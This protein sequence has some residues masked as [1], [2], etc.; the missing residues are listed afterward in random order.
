MKIKMKSEGRYYLNGMTPTIFEKG[1]EYD[2]PD[3]VGKYFVSKG[4][5]EKEEEGDLPKRTYNKRK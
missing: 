3:K 5:V 4:L 1:A 2:V